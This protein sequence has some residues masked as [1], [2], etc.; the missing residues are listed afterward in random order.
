MRT[1]TPFMRTPPF[2]A[3]RLLKDPLLPIRLVGVISAQEFR[4]SR[5]KE[6]GV[7]CAFQV[8]GKQDNFR[9]GTNAYLLNTFV[10]G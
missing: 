7:H 8:L 1:P 4:V 3:S 2:L 5:D 10:T 9:S 6:M